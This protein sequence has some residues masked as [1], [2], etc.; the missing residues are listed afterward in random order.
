MRSTQVKTTRGILHYYR[1]FDR[2]E[3]SI[4]MQDAQTID[5]YR[6]IKSSHPDCDECG[7]FFAFSKKQFDEGYGRLVRLGKIKDGEKIK[8]DKSVSGLQGTEDGIYKFHKFYD[9]RD[10]RIPKECDPQEVYFYE[11]N[12]YE[13][14]FDW[15]GD[16][17]AMRLIILYFGVDVA[18]TIKRYSDYKPIEELIH[19]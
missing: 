19:N 5:K 14:M 8:Y 17:E 10:K 7:V 18:K 2:Y 16:A 3:G 11:Y 13:S 15:S 12:N 9:D 1:D 4:I 6:E